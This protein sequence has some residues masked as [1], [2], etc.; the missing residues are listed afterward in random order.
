MILGSINN[1]KTVEKIHPSFKKAFNFLKTIN[2]KNIETSESHIEIE[3]KDIFALVQEYQGKTKKEVILE[4]HKEYID[5]QLVIK[6]SEQMG[7][8]D[9]DKCSKVLSDYD[10]NK[11]VVFYDN[12]ASSFITVNQNEFAIFFPEDAHAPGVGNGIVKKMVIKVLA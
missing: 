11:D 3:G 5:I 6:G 12:S 4:A 7:W 2:L 9:I 8:Q 1:T 10:E